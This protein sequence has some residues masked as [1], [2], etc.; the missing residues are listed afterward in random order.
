MLIISTIWLFNIAMENPPML[1]SS[2]NHLFRL[3]PWLNHGELLV[4]TRPGK[5][6]TA[7]IWDDPSIPGAL[8]SD[9]LQQLPK[10]QQLRELCGHRQVIGRN[11]KRGASVWRAFSEDLIKDDLS[12]SGWWFGTFL[13]F[14]NIW[15]NP[16]HW[17]ILFRWVETT[18]QICIEICIDECCFLKSIQ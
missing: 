15:E 12:I 2:V 10:L 6:S 18:N 8:P 17:L 7:Q 3:G 4:I 9:F 16:S 11:K 1:L 5:N 13:I 14:H